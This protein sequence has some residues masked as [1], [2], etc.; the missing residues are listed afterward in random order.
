MASFVLGCFVVF[1]GSSDVEKPSVSGYHFYSS[2]GI[3]RRNLSAGIESP[4]MFAVHRKQNVKEIV[5]CG[6]ETLEKFAK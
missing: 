2:A 5:R 3:V 1:S 4:K 6:T